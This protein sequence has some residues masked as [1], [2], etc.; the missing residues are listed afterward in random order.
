MIKLEEGIR[1]YVC[2]RTKELF[3]EKATIEEVSLEFFPE[4]F[5]RR[6]FLPMYPVFYKIQIPIGIDINEEELKIVIQLVYG[7]DARECM[8]CTGTAYLKEETVVKLKEPGTCKLGI[9]NNRIGADDYVKTRKGNFERIH[10]FYTED[11]VCAELF[12]QDLYECL[13]YWKDELPFED[14]PA[15][16]FMAKVWRLVQET[17]NNDYTKEIK[18]EFYPAIDRESPI[19][20]EEFIIWLEGGFF[21][22][23]R[24]YPERYEFVC[25]N[26]GRYWRY[27]HR[28]E[29]TGMALELYDEKMQKLE[30]DL[31][32]E[33]FELDR[34]SITIAP[35]EEKC[36]YIH[37]AE[38]RTSNFEAVKK[39][40]SILVENRKGNL[41]SKRGEWQ[42]LFTVNEIRNYFF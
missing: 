20:Y 14:R 28:H 21:L 6:S 15:T 36:P 30:D 11:K 18:T 5:I 40:L 10:Y 37:V 26:P 13:E 39:F 1:E 8:I 4:G 24:R 34:Y 32:K 19:H 23:V 9:R 29:L 17:F 35:M 27:A 3:G 38:V 16:D 42:N 33:M 22:E 41:L 25:Q 2:R 12:L 7:E 31:A